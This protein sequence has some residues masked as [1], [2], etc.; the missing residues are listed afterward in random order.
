MN[1]ID[2]LLELIL[3]AGIPVNQFGGDQ[4]SIFITYQ[5]SATQAQITQAQTIINSFDWSDA[6]H[7]IWLLDK[8][9]LQHIDDINSMQNNVLRAIVLLLI[10]EL[11][12]LRS[13]VVG[14]T[15]T[16]FD[17]A[18]MTAG[19]GITSPQVTVTGARFGDAVDVLAP[20]SLA[21]I[22]VTGYV[23]ANDKVVIRLQNGT[24][25]AINLASGT[26]TVVVHRPVV[27]NPRTAAQ[28][29]AAIIDKIQTGLAD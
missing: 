13:E 10:D 3:A 24:A 25:G 14:S 1:K 21:G 23:D 29:K 20:Y 9:R 5:P 4:G 26:W 8:N 19:T 17:P 12:I 27:L 11:N 28:A 18:N 22:T 16:V 6:A 7:V 15:T 2:H